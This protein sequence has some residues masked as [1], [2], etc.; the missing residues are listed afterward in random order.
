MEPES[1]CSKFG[2]STSVPDSK[3]VELAAARPV[4]ER[5]NSAT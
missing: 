4:L 3:D 5:G 2:A 1:I